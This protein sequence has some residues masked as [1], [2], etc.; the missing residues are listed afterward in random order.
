MRT[1]RPWDG[2]HAEETNDE[3]FYLHARE[4]SSSRARN[5]STAALECRGR[6]LPSLGQSLMALTMLEADT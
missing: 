4:E 1:S 2:R 3:R 6:K 5:Q